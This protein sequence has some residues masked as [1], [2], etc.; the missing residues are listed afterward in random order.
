MKKIIIS[1]ATSLDGYIEGPNGEVDW[2]VFSEETG[3][4]LGE[5]LHDIDTILYG[6]IS[7]EA[8]GNYIPSENASPYEKD[9]YNTT[10]KMQKYVFSTSKT[11]FEGNPAIIKDNLNYAMNELK[12]QEGKNIWLYGGA[13]LISSFVNLN[14]IDEFRIAV[15]PIILGNGKPLFKEI[16]SRAKLKLLK[17]NAGKS[18]IVELNYEKLNDNF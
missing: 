3:K 12:Q 15:M 10:S 13:S 14:L 4:V 8:W 1:L 18:G 17:T 16:Q 11:E 5:F 7:Y 9:F 2:M 6:R